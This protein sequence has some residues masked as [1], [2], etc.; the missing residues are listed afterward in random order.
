M[1]KKPLVSI[2]VPIYNVED[3][4]EKAV[5]CILEQ[6][7]KNIEVIL[8]DDCSTDKSLKIVKQFKKYENVQL[9]TN[10]K[11]GGAAYA[12][13]RGLDIA[14][15]EYI[16]FIDPDDFIDKNYYSSLIE[17]A[18]KEDADIVICDINIVYSNGNSDRRTCGNLANNKIDFIIYQ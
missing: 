12:R 5:T 7:Y 15:G 1:R 18:I 3:Y 8:I 4:V 14:K 17:S 11:N 16:G 6:D 2:I 10:H 13:N 9:I